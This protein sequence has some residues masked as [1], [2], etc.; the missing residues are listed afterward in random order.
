MKIGQLKLKAWERTGAG[1]IARLKAGSLLEAIGLVELS[2]LQ[3]LAATPFTQLANLA[4][5][6]AMSVPLHWSESGLPVGVHF[7]A[8]SGEEALLFRLAGQLERAA[9]WA[10]RRPRLG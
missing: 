3:N 8:P 2:A 10:E 6:P 5:L 9:P 7:T 4:G 1:L